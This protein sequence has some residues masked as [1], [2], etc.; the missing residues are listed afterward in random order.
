M[1]RTMTLRKR[2]LILAMG[3]AASLIVAYRLIREHDSGH[4]ALELYGN[5]D[6][7]E[8]ELAFRQPGRLSRMTHEEGDRVQAGELL[9]EIDD[10]PYQNSRA[11]AEAQARQAQAGLDKLHRGHRRQEIAQAEQTVRQSE[12]AFTL[13]TRELQRYGPV[14]ETGASTRQALDQARSQKDQA[15]AQLASAREALALSR[16]GFRR[17]DIA[18]SEAGLAGAKANLAQAETA[19]SDTRLH[20]PVDAV[21]LSRIREPGS[22]VTPQE[23]VYTLSLRDPIHV[24]AYVSEPHLGLAVPGTPVTVQTDSSDKTYHG[25]I[26]FVSPRAEFTPKSVETTELRTD[27]VYRLRIVV[28]DADDALR[29]G[30]PVTV[31]MSLPDGAP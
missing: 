5:V 6:I 29:Q 10:T 11:L 25:Q 12:A 28:H 30:M 16:E 15:A 7:R 23:P 3:L 17:E 1:N 24:R 22:M 4:G 27:L 21:I 19:L 26:G 2:P 9:A 8:V 18:A 20:A 14:A 31:R 13:A